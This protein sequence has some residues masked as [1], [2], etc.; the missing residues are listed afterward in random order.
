MAAEAGGPPAENACLYLS[1]GGPAA[2]LAVFVRLY[3]FTDNI[4]E[5]VLHLAL[6]IMIAKSEF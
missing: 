2:S 3:L 4:N 6:L 5:F 1:F